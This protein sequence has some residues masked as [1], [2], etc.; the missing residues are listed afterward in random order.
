MNR[1]R[2]RSVQARRYRDHRGAEVGEKISLVA[3]DPRRANA[4]AR[5]AASRSRS[6]LSRPWSYASTTSRSALPRTKRT[7]GPSAINC[8]VVS[9]GNSPEGDVATDHDGLNPFSSDFSKHRPQRLQIAV[10]VVQR[11]DPHRP[12]Q[13]RTTA[14]RSLAQGNSFGRQCAQSDTR[15]KSGPRSESRGG[16]VADVHEW[17]PE[18]T[19]AAPNARDTLTPACL[20]TRHL[21]ESRLA[22]AWRTAAEPSTTPVTTGFEIRE[23]RLA[24]GHAAATIRARQMLAR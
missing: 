14:A 21:Q 23:T 17:K 9:R 13:H 12:N 18:A 16:S 22:S 3:R 19:S 8:S 11:C 1:D 2:R 20:A 7:P 5:S 6:G 10:D 24:Y 15:T 4:A